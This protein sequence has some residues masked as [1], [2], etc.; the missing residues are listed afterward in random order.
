MV[1]V[2]KTNVAREFE[3]HFLMAFLKN[4]LEKGNHPF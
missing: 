3:A 1:E 4:I 2:F